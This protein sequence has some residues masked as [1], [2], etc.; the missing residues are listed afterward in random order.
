VFFKNVDTAVDC[1]RPVLKG[2]DI[3]KAFDF[4][5][6]IRL[7]GIPELDFLNLENWTLAVIREKSPDKQCGRLVTRYRKQ[8]DLFQ[9]IIYLDDTLFLETEPSRMKRKIVAV[10]EFTHFAAC[11]YAY[12]RDK[13]QF[14]TTLEQRLDSAIDEIFNPE[15]TVLYHL[16]KDKKPQESETLDTFKH[17]QHAHFQLGLEKIELSYTDLYLNLLFSR[18]AFEEFFELDKQ[19]QFYHLW[20]DNERQQA[21]DLYHDLVKQAAREKWIPEQF[22][23]DQA[24]EWIKGYI[25][26]PIQV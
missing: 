24:D 6:T 3:R 21:L 1:L 13:S 23:S 9:C 19:K 16:L 18:G 11:I 8:Q 4:E 5:K 15:V 7:I 25:Q 10:H 17:I 22:A 2:L 14:I 26:N 12:S 20:R